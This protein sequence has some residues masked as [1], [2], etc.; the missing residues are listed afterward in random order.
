MAPVKAEKSHVTIRLTG[1]C[2]NVAPGRQYDRVY[3]GAACPEGHEGFIRQFVRVG[4][5]LVMP[6]KDH[7]LRIHRIDE[8]TWLHFT[9]LSVSFSTLVVPVASEQ[10]LFHLRTYICQPRKT[11]VPFTICFL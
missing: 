6:F 8:D 4:G 7:L 3:C 9:M 1:N 2:L 10:T 11:N 5:I